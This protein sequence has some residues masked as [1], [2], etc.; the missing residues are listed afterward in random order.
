M[1]MVL[2]IRPLLSAAAAADQR[3]QPRVET[4]LL[5]YQVGRRSQAVAMAGTLTQQG[6]SRAVAAAGITGQEQL[7]ELVGST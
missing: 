3:G 1:R 7:E 6:G 4:T 2:A 5:A